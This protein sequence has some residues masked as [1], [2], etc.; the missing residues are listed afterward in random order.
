MMTHLLQHTSLFLVL[1]NQCLVQLSGECLFQQKGVPVGTT[2]VPRTSFV[3]PVCALRKRSLIGEL[4]RQ[5]EG[6]DDGGEEAEEAEVT[7][8]V[9]NLVQDA[10]NVISLST[11]LASDAPSSVSTELDVDTSLINLSMLPMVDERD[12]LRR[13]QSVEKDDVRARKDPVMLSRRYI[14]FARPK[15]GAAGLPHGRR[16]ASEQ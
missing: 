12:L 7:E 5:I 11:P 10:A 14:L 16:L 15:S 2:S 4:S 1:P 8:H 13:A 6:S 3:V 9:Q